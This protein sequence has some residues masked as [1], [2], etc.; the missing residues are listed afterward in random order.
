MRLDAGDIADLRPVIAAAVRA[1][2]DEI[3]AADAKLG[4][5]LAYPQNQA[6][7][8]LGVAPTVLRDARLRGELKGKLVGKKIVYSRTELLRF[9]AEGES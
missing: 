2:L 6:A 9:L 3:R 5:Q 1:T 4:N 7:S 8:L